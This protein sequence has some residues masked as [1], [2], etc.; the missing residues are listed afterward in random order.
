[1][2]VLTSIMI[3]YVKKKNSWAVN[4][5]KSH[6]ASPVVYKDKNIFQ[7]KKTLSFFGT[8]TKMGQNRGTV[9]FKLY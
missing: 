3:I 8:R 2:I 7:K 6:Y 5:I 4:H 1:M 9:Y